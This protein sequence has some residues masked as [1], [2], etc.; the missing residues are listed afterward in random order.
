MPGEHINFFK[1]WRKIF[2]IIVYI[3]QYLFYS[4]YFTFFSPRG[5]IF[6]I[7]N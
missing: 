4:I 6:V 7:I 5:N 2:K 1:N 3:L